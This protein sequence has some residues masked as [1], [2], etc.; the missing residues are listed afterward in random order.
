MQNA[1]QYDQAIVSANI[2]GDSN[3]VVDVAYFETEYID[4]P[5]AEPQADAAADADSDTDNADA[6]QP[7]Q[8]PRPTTET[9]SNI[10]KARRARAA[11]EGTDNPEDM[12]ERMRQQLNDAVA[13]Q[14]AAEQ[15]KPADNNKQ[16][17]DMP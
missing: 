13:A 17:F 7:S 4:N 16:L 3:E 14:V 10:L 9:V 1:V 5:E 8:P 11:A 2:S 12:K 6:E 15:G